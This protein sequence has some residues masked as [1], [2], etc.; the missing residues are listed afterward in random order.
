[1]S[2]QNRVK[3]NVTMTAMTALTSVLA[4]VALAS[5]APAR[6]AMSAAKAVRVA[7]HGHRS[8]RTHRTMRR[9]ATTAASQT[10][11]PLPIA[12]LH[13]RA[14][15]QG[16]QAVVENR[17]D[18]PVQVELSQAGTGQAQTDP[19]AAIFI[20][21]ENNMVGVAPVILDYVRR[22]YTSTGEIG[23]IRMYFPRPTTP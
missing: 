9:L 19:P 11:A 14:T 12:T 7:T 23:S 15:P 3:K 20:N 10:A 8:P 6:G 21:N 13:L 2:L 4:M 18:G 22:E 17:I 1:M 5:V 16:L